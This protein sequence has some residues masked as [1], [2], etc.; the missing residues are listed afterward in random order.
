MT[1]KGKVKDI[2]F[3]SLHVSEC[4]VHY[5]LPSFGGAFPC[6]DFVRNSFRLCGKLPWVDQGRAEQRARVEAF[7]DRVGFVGITF[8]VR[9]WMNWSVQSKNLHRRKNKGQ[10]GEGFHNEGNWEKQAAYA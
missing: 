6:R 7:Q 1:R 3:A 10:L 5:M 8:L 4:L 2:G 9:T